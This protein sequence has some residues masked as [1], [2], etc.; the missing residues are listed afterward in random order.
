MG[1][2]IQRQALISLI[3]QSA[4]QNKPL[5]ANAMF[6]LKT[7]HGFREF[8]SPNAKVDVA[9]TASVLVVKDF[10]ADEQWAAKT[11]E[12]QRRLTQETHT[13]NAPSLRPALP[14][15]SNAS[16]EPAAMPFYDVPTWR[17]RG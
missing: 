4:V 3:V 1:R 14:A 7:I 12:Q 8:D 16:L 15:A 10:G 6:L 9:V 5:N 13:A 17:G 2:E 11:P